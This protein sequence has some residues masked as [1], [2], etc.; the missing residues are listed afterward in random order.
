MLKRRS[1]I[2]SGLTLAASSPLW[3][4]AEDKKERNIKKALKYGMIKDGTAPEDKF[5]IAKEAGFDGVEP[6]SPFTADQLKNFQAATHNT[7]TLIPGTVF[8]GN[9]GTKLVD[10][11]ISVRKTAI[12]NFKLA[13]AQTRDLGGTTVLMY[14]GIVNEQIS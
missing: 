6:N 13:L 11:D 7:G 4:N 14:P 12:E 2:K 10:P 8:G 1:F 3:L 9:H 5:R